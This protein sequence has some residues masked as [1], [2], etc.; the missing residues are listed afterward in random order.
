MALCTTCSSFDLYRVFNSLD[1]DSP[2]DVDP[3]PKYF[4]LGDRDGLCFWHSDNIST[5]QIGA[6]SGCGLCTLLL[7]AFKRKGSVAAQ[8][9]SNLPIILGR[10]RKIEDEWND[11][12][13]FSPYMEPELMAYFVSPELK[14]IQL[15]NLD[16]SIDNSMS[17]LLE[18]LRYSTNGLLE[19]FW[20]RTYRP[21]IPTA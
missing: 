21:S 1:V 3:D 10:S 7:D 11:P 12:P 17:Y 8:E 16:I 2:T 4:W 13:R 6:S 18:S 19:S 14:L 9:A 15:C 5:I 20:R